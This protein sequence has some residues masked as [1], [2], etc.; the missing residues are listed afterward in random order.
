[1]GYA[2]GSYLDPRFE[3]SESL[4]IEEYNGVFSVL[5]CYYWFRNVR[6]IRINK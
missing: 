1:M 2:I 6:N 3:L 5:H 4:L